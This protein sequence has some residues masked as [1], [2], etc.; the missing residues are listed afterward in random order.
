MDSLFVVP[1]ETHFFQYSGFWIDY[2]LRQARPQLLTFDMWLQN[3]A[4]N[5]KHENTKK[6]KTSRTSDSVLPNCWNAERFV[7]YL[8]A[9]AT[10]CFAEQDYRGLMSC[11]IKALHVS[12][13]GETP[14]AKRF[15]EKSVEHAEYAIFLRKLYPGAKF[16]HVLRNPY[17]TLV[18]L[19]RHMGHSKGYPFLGKAIDAL[20]NSY[21]YLYK[22]SLLIDDYTVLRYEDLI[23]KPRDTMQSIAHFIGTEFDEI[24]LKPTS[25][26]EAWLGNSTSGDDFDGIAKSPLFD[27]KDKI[28][29]FEIRLI[30]LL[31]KHVLKDYYYEQVTAT[32][33]V[34]QPCLKENVKTYLANRFL[35]A[36]IS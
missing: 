13:Y 36:Q 27:W 7:E 1:I 26:G 2:A 3:L 14:R 6:F 22:N 23:N 11:Y 12:L 31:F 20:E 35:L 5:I 21:Y 25:L 17:A 19:R 30:N 32:K 9:E 18:A 24:L 4:Q 34:F 29:P 8:Q 33:S 15:V 16:L 10:D 28:T